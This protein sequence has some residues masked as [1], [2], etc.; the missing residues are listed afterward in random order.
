MILY[1]IIYFIQKGTPF[2]G[3]VN[4]PRP[5]NNISSGA[6]PQQAFVIFIIILLVFLIIFQ[7]KKDKK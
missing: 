6:T 3:P 7:T 2:S 5:N 1:N 4:A